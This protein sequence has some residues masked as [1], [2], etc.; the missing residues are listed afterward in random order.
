MAEVTD[1]ALSTKFQEINRNYPCTMP[2]WLKI[3]LTIT[4]TI[5]AITVIVVLINATKFGNYL[6]RKH[7]QN[8]R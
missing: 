6:L 3:M 7:L 8:N 4:S 5:I 2:D 1:H